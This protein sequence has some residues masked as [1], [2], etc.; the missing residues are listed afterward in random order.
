MTPGEQR[1]FSLEDRIQSLRKG[2]IDPALY[3]PARLNTAGRVRAQCACGR[4]DPLWALV[5][6]RGLPDLVP[7]GRDG[8]PDES[9]RTSLADMRFACNGC[10]TLWY[11]RRAE[12]FID[13]DE[14][15]RLYEWRWREL[16]GLS[17]AAID[18]ARGN[19]R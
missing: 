6:V 11:R 7:P 18:D 9:R 13:G 16:L 5:D 8:R 1:P 10:H 15:D 4:S 12:W 2:D 3:V 14:N 17:Q 19:I